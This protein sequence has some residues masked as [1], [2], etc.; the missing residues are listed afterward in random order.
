MR[1]AVDGIEAVQVDTKRTRD[2]QLDILLLAL[3]TFNLLLHKVVK[4]LG[5][6]FLKYFLVLSPPL[7]LVFYFLLPVT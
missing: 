7:I 3:T 1:G 5:W 2:P 4:M 6:R